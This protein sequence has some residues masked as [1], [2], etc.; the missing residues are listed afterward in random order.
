MTYILLADLA[1]FIT[2]L[3]AAGFGVI[4]LKTLTSIIAILTSSLCL[5]YLYLSRE[6]FKKRSLWM[7]AAAGAILFCILYSLA[8][9]FP[10]PAPSPENIHIEI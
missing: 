9:N 7:T 10:C 4:W 8:L 1:L 3:I 5:G 2:Y 6:I